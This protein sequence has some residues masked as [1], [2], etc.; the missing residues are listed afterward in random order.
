M[1]LSGACI[2]SDRD[3]LVK[4]INSLLNMQ[5]DLSVVETQIIQISSRV[6]ILETTKYAGTHIGPYMPTDN[7]NLWVVTSAAGTTIV[8]DQGI[9]DL[10]TLA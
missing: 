9:L 5:N 4:D 6:K 2:R 1:A 7:S 8:L 10:N 3:E